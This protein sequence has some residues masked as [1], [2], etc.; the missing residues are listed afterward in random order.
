MNVKYEDKSSLRREIKKIDNDTDD[1]KKFLEVMVRI[2]LL[3]L[4]A[5]E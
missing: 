5:R 2:M 3:I 1:R 4:I